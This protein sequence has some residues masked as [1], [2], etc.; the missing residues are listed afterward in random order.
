MSPLEVEVLGDPRRLRIV[1]AEGKKHEV[2]GRNRGEGKGGGGHDWSHGDTG[3]GYGPW[4]PSAG[5]VEEAP[6]ME[7]APGMTGWR[8]G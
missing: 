6:R 2:R 3:Q 5:A 7:E 8:R 4:G 1:V